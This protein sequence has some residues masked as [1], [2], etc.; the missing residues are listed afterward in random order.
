MHTDRVQIIQIKHN[1]E[2]LI[3]LQDELHSVILLQ[4]VHYIKAH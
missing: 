2:V 3:Y 1:I 4:S